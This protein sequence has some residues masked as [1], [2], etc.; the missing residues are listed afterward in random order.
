MSIREINDRYRRLFANPYRT[1][2][3]CPETPPREL[4]LPFFVILG[5]S[6]G[7]GM[8][9]ALYLAAVFLYP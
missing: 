6:L 9:L 5:I 3:H 8:G 1:P 7:L 2:E 4:G